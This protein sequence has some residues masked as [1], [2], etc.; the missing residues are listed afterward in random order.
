M[1]TVIDPTLRLTCASGDPS[2]EEELASDRLVLRDDRLL[3]RDISTA[4]AASVSLSP[5]LGTR[6]TAGKGVVGLG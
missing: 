2:S 1:L 5:L 6:S 4:V 3:C